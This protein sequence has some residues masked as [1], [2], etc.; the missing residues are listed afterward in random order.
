MSGNYKD[1]GKLNNKNKDALN[2]YYGLLND[3]TL[4]QFYN[5]KKKFVVEDEKG[6][7]VELTYSA[8]T[9]KQRKS[10]IERIMNNNAKIAKIYVGTS[11]LGYKY[12]TKS[13][14]EYNTL[15]SLGIKGVI[16][17]DTHLEGFSK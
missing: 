12:Y 11:K 2:E 9:T 15:R 5:N 8:M 4:E 1:I 10:V 3:K 6:K 17:S 7:R 14:D 13:E 16:Y